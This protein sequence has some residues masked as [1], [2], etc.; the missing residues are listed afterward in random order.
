LRALRQ[1]N[2]RTYWS[3]QV[4]SLV[5]TWMQRTAQQWLVYRLT[6]S[7]LDLGLVASVSFAPFLLFA[8]LAG[9]LVDRVDRRRLVLCTQTGYMLLGVLQAVL[10]ATGLI[11]LWHVVI[12]A[13]CLGLA[14]TLELPARLALIGRVVPAE[15]LLNAVALH[16]SA[17]NA[18]RILGPAV[19]G[20]LLA[21]YGE[22]VVFTANAASYVP[23][24]VGLARMRLAPVER[25]AAPA[26]A[27]VDLRAGLRYALANARV[28][29]LTSI[30]SAQGLLVLPYV[31]L[32][33]VFADEVLGA[34]APGLGWLTAATG[35]GALLG[36][37]AL[38]ALGE[39]SQRG[40][41]LV[42]G[43]FGFAF[44]LG[45]FALSR[46][47]ALS[48]VILVGVGWSQVMHLTTSNTLV[49][50][51]VPDA[52]RGRVLGLYLWLHGGTLPVGALL[53]GALGQRW[54][55]P[56]ALLGA[57]L[58]YSL[59]LAVIVWRHRAMTRWA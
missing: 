43:M 52:L 16:S 53:L 45:C 37:V 58:V 9:L 40:R 21:R 26:S 54:G 17:F 33:P 39:V 24:I 19:A 2:F 42:V 32:M 1:P 48:L 47:L 29:I 34:G 50:L 18:A 27:W 44:G 10:T 13:F 6:G 36:A 5:G 7:P 46:S 41:L 56:A 25:L 11:E 57:S 28:R 49:Q 23:V 51:A 3:G 4:V 31:F 22:P 15:D 55:T 14:E 35:L 59:L 8:P 20:L 38:L 12:I 30:V